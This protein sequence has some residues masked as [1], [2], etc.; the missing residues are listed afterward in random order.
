MRPSSLLAV[1]LLLA[2]IVLAIVNAEEY[3]IAAPAPSPLPLAASPPSPPPP[4]V[5]P[6]PPPPPP[7]PVKP[8]AWSPVTDVNDRTVRQVGQFAVHAYCLSTGARLVF[9]NVVSGQTQPYNDG[10]SYQLVITVAGP[11]AKT[12]RYSVSVWG[13]L[14]TTTWQLRSFAPM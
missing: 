4:V 9:V 3:T 7:P 6:P 10:N 5:S 8:P 1:A 14:G 13:I 12:T 11:G 2:T